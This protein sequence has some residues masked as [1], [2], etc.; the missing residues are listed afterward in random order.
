MARGEHLWGAGG[1]AH[2]VEEAAGAGVAYR[3]TGDELCGGRSSGAC[4][5]AV[6]VAVAMCD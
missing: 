5:D 1:V 4:G 6:A 2:P 3:G